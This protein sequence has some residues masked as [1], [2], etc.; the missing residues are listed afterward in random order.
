MAQNYNP[1]LQSTSDNAKQNDDSKRTSADNHAVSRRLHKELMSL[2]MSQDKSISAFPDGD[3]FFSWIGT[4]MGP[5][6]SVYENMKFKLKLKFPS[7]Y[8]YSAPF[9]KFITP[10]FHPNVDTKGNICLDI[11]KDRWSAL[12]DVR[13]L[14]ISIQA[15]LGEPNVDSP[16]NTLAAEKWQKPEEYKKFV[17]EMYKEA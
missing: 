1:S 9:V 2:M 17:L 7:S 4:I 11:L 3:N 13:T 16:L 15:L 14:L 12:Y 5:K 6:D 8:P 10:C